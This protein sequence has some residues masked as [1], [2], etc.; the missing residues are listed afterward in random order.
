MTLST[1]IPLAILVLAGAASGGSPCLDG[2]RE[3]GTVP[4][5]VLRTELGAIEIELVP[6]AAPT[7]V[8]W[9]VRLARGPLFHPDLAAP[10]GAPVGFYDGLTFDF[11]RPHVELITETRRPAHLFTTETRI[12]AAALGLDRSLIADSA[13]AM[14]VLQQELLPEVIRHK[15]RGEVTPGLRAWA[16]RWY[17]DRNPDFLVGV[18][19]REVNEAL[20]YAY[21]PGLASLAPERG[22]VALWPESPRRSTARLAI[23][24]TDLPERTG[25]W[26]VVG[27]VIEGLGVAEAIASRPLAPGPLYSQHRPLDPVAI[28]ST[29]V[30][31]RPGRRGGHGNPKEE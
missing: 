4:F 22:T 7:A 28:E 18:S 1:S 2:S 24:L 10:A 9:L 5:L 16:D 26:M 27:R 15:K 21:E 12:D 13:E 23:F 17:E 30:E 6:E 3:V 29:H 8:G 14:S 20:G 25:R 31:C 11:T 19:H